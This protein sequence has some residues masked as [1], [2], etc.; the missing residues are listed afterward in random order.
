VTHTLPFN[1]QLGQAAA[2]VILQKF[3]SEDFAKHE[4]PKYVV[5]LKNMGVFTGAAF[6][7]LS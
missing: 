3:S 1:D 4:P 2:K 5:Y 7:I 6:K